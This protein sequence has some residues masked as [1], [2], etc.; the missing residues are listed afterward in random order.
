MTYWLRQMV[1]VGAVVVGLM[2]CTCLAAGTMA[3]QSADDE[4]QEQS[5]NRE[6]NTRTKTEARAIVQQKAQV[7]A[8]QRQAR[9]ASMAWYGMSNSRP[10]AA[11]T[12]F[13]TRYSPVWESP[14]GQPYSWYP[15]YTYNYPSTVFYG[16]W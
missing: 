1:G 13:M 3:K 2:A 5:W 14:G 6:Q 16:R 15:T 4:S 7:H 8:E 10:T 9:M 12:P 11:T